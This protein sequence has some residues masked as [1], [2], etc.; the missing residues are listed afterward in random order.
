VNFR[1]YAQFTPLRVACVYGGVDIQP[2]IAQ[3]RMG[4]EVLIRYPRPPARSCGPEECQSGS[5]S[6][7]RS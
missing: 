2:Q 4:C 3:L 5:G 1:E 6:D 7:H